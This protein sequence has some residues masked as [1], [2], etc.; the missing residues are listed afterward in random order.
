MEHNRN[1]RFLIPP[2]VLAASVYLGAVLDPGIDIAAFYQKVSAISGLSSLIGIVA[3]GGVAVIALGFVLSS[4]S[5]FLLRLISTIRGL[6]Y[7]AHVSKESF[8]KIWKSFGLTSE[9]EPKL[10]LY[11]LAAYDHAVLPTPLNLWMGRR[12]TTFMVSCHCVIA[13]F[14]AHLVGTLFRLAQ[15]CTW[16]YI[17]VILSIVMISNAAFASY[18]TMKMMEFLSNLDVSKL[19]N[20]QKDANSN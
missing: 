1:L 12:W 9:P 18:Q 17:T 15:T 4:V 5:I 16:W 3:S 6:D 10:S 11:V 8:S 13:L 7:E 20:R 19:P 2:F 14:G